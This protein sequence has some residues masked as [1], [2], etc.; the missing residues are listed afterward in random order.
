MEENNRCLESELTSV[1]R[2]VIHTESSM[3]EWRGKCEKFEETCRKSNEDN[4]RLRIDLNDVH[5]RNKSLCAK[6]NI[7]EEQSRKN[8]AEANLAIK[9]R[10][11]V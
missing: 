11:K 7:L 2:D 5:E 6:V 9:Q 3:K 1:R 8:N 4:E 10:D